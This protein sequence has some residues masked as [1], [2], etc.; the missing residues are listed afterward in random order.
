MPVLIEAIN[1]VIQLET[2]RERYPGGIETLIARIR[3]SFAK[4]HVVIA[5]Y[6]SGLR[7]DARH[8]LLTLTPH[9]V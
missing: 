5:D 8:Q 7:L 3:D 9:S 1:I 2:L 4:T 6:T